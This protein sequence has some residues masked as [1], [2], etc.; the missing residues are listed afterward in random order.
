LFLPVK[1]NIYTENLY[2]NYDELPFFASGFFKKSAFSHD[3][4]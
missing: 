4:T 2:K 1:M 3:Y